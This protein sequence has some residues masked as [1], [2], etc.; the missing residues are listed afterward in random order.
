MP[1]AWNASATLTDP[2]AP[3]Q[4][5]VTLTTYVAFA[6]KRA[7]ELTH[8]S[9]LHT[10]ARH[11]QVSLRG[12]PAAAHELRR[13]VKRRR[14][15]RATFRFLD[16]RLRK[17]KSGCRATAAAA[18]AAAAALAWAH[19][20]S[21]SFTPRSAMRRRCESLAAPMFFSTVK[22]CLTMEEGVEGEGAEDAAFDLLN[23][24][25]GRSSRIHYSA[26]TRTLVEF[27]YSSSPTRGRRRPQHRGVQAAERDKAPRRLSPSKAAQLWKTQRA[28]DGGSVSVSSSRGGGPSSLSRTA[29]AALAA[30]G[31]LGAASGGSQ[32]LPRVSFD[33]VPLPRN[34]NTFYSKHPEVSP[35]RAMVQE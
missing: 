8:G 4:A 15:K 12:E 24:S 30:Q 25:L 23:V 1:C 3:V 14:K 5:A 17:S 10:M 7:S 16:L 22:K 18:A 31:L 20:E 34:L 32:R 6:T 33:P 35:F 26:P 21:R 19:D 9:L 27:H 28:D 2:A 11:T 29:P 13:T